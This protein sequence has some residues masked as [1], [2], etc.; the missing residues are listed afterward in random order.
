MDDRYA[1]WNIVNMADAKAS[2]EAFRKALGFYDEIG[3]YVKV[4]REV[5][6]RFV[7]TAKFVMSDMNY[8]DCPRWLDIASVLVGK[9]LEIAIPK[10]FPW[11]AYKMPIS[12]DS[13]YLIKPSDLQRYFMKGNVKFYNRQSED[14]REDT[15]HKLYRIA[16]ITDEMTVAGWMY[17]SQ[18]DYEQMID[19]RMMAVNAGEKFTTNYFQKYILK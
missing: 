10:A 12:Y 17:N 19:K 5:A 13:M 4:D 6:S 14:F 9:G 2:V 1:S 3:E 8:G 16:R 7:D 15:F 18:G 11:L